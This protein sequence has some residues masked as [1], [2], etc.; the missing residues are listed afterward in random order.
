MSKPRHRIRST[1]SV[2]ERK[3]AFDTL[4]AAEKA[5]YRPWKTLT[6]GNGNFMVAYRCNRCKKYHYGHPPGWRY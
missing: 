3:Q 5:A 6:R 1:K 2:C 4:E